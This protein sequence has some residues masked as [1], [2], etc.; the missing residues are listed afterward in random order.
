M[1]EIIL[2]EDARGN[3]PVQEW[4]KELDGRAINSKNAR[5]ELNQIRHCMKLIERFGTRLGE[6][7]TKQ[8]DDSLWELRPGGNRIFFF[9]W[10]GNH[11]VLLHGFP[12]ETQKTPA[13]EIK[14]AKQEMQDWIIR[15]GQ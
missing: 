7:F 1:Y 4:I 15:H 8:I 11:Y 10:R 9:G 13:R 3:C 14:K 2:Y 5:I 6:K 12:K